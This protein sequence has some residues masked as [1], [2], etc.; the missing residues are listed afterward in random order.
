MSFNA[1]LTLGIL[2]P[3]MRHHHLILVT[4]CCLATGACGSDGP[5]VDAGDASVGDIIYYEPPVT[6]PVEDL[7]VYPEAGADWAVSD[8]SAE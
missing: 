4:L 2:L 7:P 1:A 3:S 5:S 6:Q 8:S